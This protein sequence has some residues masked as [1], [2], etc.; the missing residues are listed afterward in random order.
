MQSYSRTLLLQLV[1]LIFAPL[2]AAQ[3]TADWKYREG[4]HFERLVPAQGTSSAPDKI[5]VAEFFTYGCNFC[6]RMDTYIEEW[7][8][9]KPEEVNFIHIPSV[10]DP[11]WDAHARHSRHQHAGPA[12][13]C[14]RIGSAR[15]VATLTA[16]G[17]YRSANARES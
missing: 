2:A 3:E 1:I 15:T 9:T 13:D 14:G 10:G 17:S 5:E 7:R 6:Y 11:A 16:V 4:E 12:G 8:K